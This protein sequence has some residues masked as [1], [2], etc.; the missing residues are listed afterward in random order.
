MPVPDAANALSA[1]LPEIAVSG[2]P[3][4]RN[5]GVFAIALSL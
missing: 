4:A 3:A 1:D 2:T 5:H